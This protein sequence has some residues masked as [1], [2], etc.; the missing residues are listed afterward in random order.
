MFS[1]VLLRVLVQDEL[2]SRAV[3]SGR[4][5]FGFFLGFFFFSSQ[6]ISSTKFA[7]MDLPSLAV[8]GNDKDAS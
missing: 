6:I 8:C 1:E 5:G 2:P 3:K 4:L 7:L